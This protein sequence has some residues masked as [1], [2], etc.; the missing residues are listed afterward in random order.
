M[1][2]PVEAGRAPMRVGELVRLT[3]MSARA[4]RRYEGLGLIYSLGR[5][6]A[7]HRLFDGSALWCITV[8]RDL[9]ALGLTIR[10]IRELATIYRHRRDEPIGAHVAERLAAARSRIDTRRRELEQARRRID[11]FERRHAAALTAASPEAAW[12]GDPTRLDERA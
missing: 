4:I 5:S 3:G 1:T 12:T 6:P 10:E 7:G 2:A 11:D 8:I 9:R